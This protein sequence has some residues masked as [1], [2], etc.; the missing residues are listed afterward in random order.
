MTWNKK[1]K[2]AEKLVIDN[3]PAILTGV[4][5]AGTVATALLTGRT[6]VRIYQKLEEQDPNNELSPAEV[7]KLVW[8]ECIPPVVIGTA[9]IT[10]I[11]A[12]NRVS[13]RRAAALATAFS[14]SEQ[15]MQEYKAKVI[16]KFGEGKEQ[17]VR[18]AVA[19]DR[20][21]ANPPSRN[22]VIVTGDGDV[23]CYDSYSGRYFTSSAEKIRRA[24]NQLNHRLLS[25][26][27]ASLNDFYILL[28]LEQ[29]EVGEEVGW[30]SD[31]LLDVFIS[32]TVTEEERPCLVI[33]FDN[34]PIRGYHKFG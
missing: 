21:M 20:V 23:L 22:T 27:Y 15:A 3:S 16:E 26:M 24:V 28:G 7:A 4:A 12:S 10:C 9:T 33:V 11:V 31:K 25:D 17:S 18:D 2:Q 19:H 1:L 30:T 13:S 8:P 14:L 29:V 6:A 32:A 34:T 5:V